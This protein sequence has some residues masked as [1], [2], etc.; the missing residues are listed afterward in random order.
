MRGDITVIVT[1]M[2]GMQQVY[3]GYDW[4]LSEGNLV[5]S[6]RMHSHHPKRV[7]PMEN[8]RLYEVVEH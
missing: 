5:I 7:I 1:W 3:E 2:D 4:A 8:V 6:Q